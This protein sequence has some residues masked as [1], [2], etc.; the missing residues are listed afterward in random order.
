MQGQA[1]A[2][3]VAARPRGDAP[4][5]LPPT[6][7]MGRVT[8]GV[9]FHRD[10]LGFLSRARERYGD[11]FTMRMALVHAPMVVFADPRAIGQI[12]PADPSTGHTGQAR[13]DLL[14]IVPPP[15]I[16]GADGALHRTV[17]G[18]LAPVFAREALERH[19]D[20]MVKIAERHV[21]GWPRARPFQLFPRMRKIALDIFVRLLLG[22]RDEDRATALVLAT[23]RMMWTGVNP[24]LPPP[25]E[26]DGLAGVFGKALFR[27][28]RQP[29]ERLLS[30]EIEARR[31]DRRPA[32]SDVI[33]SLLE[34]DPP[35]STD[36]MLDELITLLMP[37]HES[38]PAGLTW[39]LDRLAREPEAAEHFAA[40]PDDD[41]RSD[42]CVREALRLRPAVHS[43]VRLLI[44]PMDIAGHR[45]PPGVIATIP[46][47]LVHRD[48]QAFPDPNAFRPDRF[49]SGGAAEGPHL[50]FGDGPRRCLGEAL[51]LIQIGS[52][53]PAILRG[54]ALQPLSPQPERMVVRGTVLAPHR[55]ALAVAADR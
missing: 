20:A 31:G 2:S 18:R 34:A 46:I 21:D 51:A 44:A 41:P 11:A 53:L 1:P 19:R 33:A 39:V 47:P 17:R 24:P 29:V 6:P 50:P 35:L 42:A 27:R 30:A 5:T 48:P 36:E 38:G 13:R 52:V 12:A 54:V 28:R 14:G 8:Q 9:L 4:R 40:A 43:V 25:G 3:T 22:V 32:G 26:G 10:P 23:R 49:L 16:L 15:G 37:A 45:L 7:P 55:G